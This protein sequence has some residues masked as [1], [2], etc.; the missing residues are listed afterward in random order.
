VA[1]LLSWCA[2]T[3]DAHAARKLSLAD[4]IALAKSQR[5]ESA[6]ADLDLKIA[7]VEILRAA[8]QRVRLTANVNYSDG[9]QRVNLGATDAQCTSIPGA[10]MSQI[11]QEIPRCLAASGSVRTKSSW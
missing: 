8:L 6:R 11:T 10:C 1:T 5:P 4:A 9:Y 3:P 2:I 7:D